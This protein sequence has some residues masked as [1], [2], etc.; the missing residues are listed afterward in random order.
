[1]LCSVNI[2]DVPHHVNV[3]LVINGWK[4]HVVMFI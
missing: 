4:E 1:M 2:L 3:D